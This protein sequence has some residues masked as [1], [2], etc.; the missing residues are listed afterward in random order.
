MVTAIVIQ[1]ISVDH[2]PVQLALP[3]TTIEQS[4]TAARSAEAAA[5]AHSA[6]AVAAARSAEAVA[7]AHSAEA[8]AVAHSAEAVVVA[9]AVAFPEEV[10]GEAATAVAAMAVAAEVAVRSAVAVKIRTSA[11]IIR[12]TSR[13]VHPA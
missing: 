7:V 9:P 11:F 2:E 4:P 5:V 13:I 6:E 12:C 10:L 3:L 1:I 8:V